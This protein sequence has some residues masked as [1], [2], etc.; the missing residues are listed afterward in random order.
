M[1]FHALSHAR[2]QAARAEA[3]NQV[4]ICT[5]NRFNTNSLSFLLLFSENQ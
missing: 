5:V 4:Y 3:F 2:T 1:N